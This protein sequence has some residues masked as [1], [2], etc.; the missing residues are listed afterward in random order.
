MS[1]CRRRPDDGF[2][3]GTDA[4]LFGVLI[5]VCGT[6]LVTNLWAVLDTKVAVEG[7]A[8]EAARAYVEAADASSAPALARSAARR[9]LA[10]HGRGEGATVGLSAIDG[11]ARC[12][13]VIVTVER[14]VALLEIPLLGQVGGTIRVRARHSELVDPYRSAADLPERE[15]LSACDG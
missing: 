14:D 8:L 5:F 11:F 2:V 9:V 13:R 3:A 12:S 6:V 1:R 15:R 4:L 10:D 7:A